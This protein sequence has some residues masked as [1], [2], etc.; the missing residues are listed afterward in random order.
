M[1]KRIQTLMKMGLAEDAKKLENLFIKT[2]PVLANPARKELLG[3]GLFSYLMA[4]HLRKQ[5]ITAVENDLPLK[6]QRQMWKEYR[7]FVK[8]YRDVCEKLGLVAQKYE[9]KGRHAEGGVLPP[10]ELIARLNPSLKEE[11]DEDE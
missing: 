1:D 2:Y 4:E 9:R 10:S 8:V 3:E 11:E 6:Q 5:I 7:D